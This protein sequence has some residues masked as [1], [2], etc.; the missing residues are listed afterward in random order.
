MLIE[1]RVANFKSIRDEQVISLVADKDKSHI[2]THSF[3]TGIK[4]IPSVLKS[5]A[6]FGA[7]ASGKSNLIAALEFVHKLVRESS[8]IPQ[9]S[10]FNIQPFRLDK[11]KL[12][13]PSEFEVTF[14]INQTRYQ[15][16]FAVNS[17]RVT[18]EWLLVYEK[19]KPQEWFTR[20]YDIV[21]G[22]YNYK[23]GSHLKGK[24]KLW[25]DSTRDN[26]LFLSTAVQLNSEQ[27][28]PVFEWI[29][30]NLI[31]LGTNINFYPEDS[32]AMLNQDEKKNAL[33]DLVIKA[34]IGIKHI[35]LESKKGRKETISLNPK[36]KQES[37][38]HS[39][40][41]EILVPFFLHET[42]MGSA[43]FNVFEE[44]IG[45][46]RLFY[47][48]GPILETLEHGKTL[49]IDEL[50]SSLHTFIVQWLISMFNSNKYNK[51]GAQIIFT[52]HD[53]NLLNQ[54]IMRR[55]QIWFIEKDKNQATHIYS[56]SEFSPRRHEA[57]GKGYLQGRYGA[58][59]FIE[60]S[61]HIDDIQTQ[62]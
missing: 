26:A 54:D 59:P 33:I 4:S 11:S 22:K 9:G 53:T 1:F 42:D 62:R 47:L 46:Q 48:A 10:K 29:S 25:R 19:A 38:I 58:L 18:D 41:K 6:I 13:K 12:N 55:D 30:E 20:R 8:I 23:L 31:F 52:T 50:D 36:Q 57:L 45:T 56:L 7:N 28:I 32:I 60:D 27:L 43:L 40:E 16:G 39:E 44:S 15:Y 34:D 17:E 5:A 3:H 14:L 24:K 2:K 21:K 61:D 49:I 37:K 51:K 35:K